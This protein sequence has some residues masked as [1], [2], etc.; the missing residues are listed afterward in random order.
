MNG[1]LF[2]FPYTRAAS[3]GFQRTFVTQDNLNF[4]TIVQK[5][6][7]QS[8]NVSRSISQHSMTPFSEATGDLAA[9]QRNVMLAMIRNVSMRGSLKFSEQ[10]NSLLQGRSSIL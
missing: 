5:C 3:G 6:A 9:S 7:K 2:T 4:D 10:L 8:T 1:P